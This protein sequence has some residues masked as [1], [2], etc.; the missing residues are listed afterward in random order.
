MDKTTAKRVADL[1]RNI[2]WHEN[3]IKDLEMALADH[4]EV[5]IRLTGPYVSLLLGEMKGN[6][7]AFERSLEKI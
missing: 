1:M 4:R 2:E 5:T 3:T 7:A 6:L